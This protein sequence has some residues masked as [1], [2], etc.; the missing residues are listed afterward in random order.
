MNI[1]YAFDYLTT[2]LISFR[3]R[4]LGLSGFLWRVDVDEGIVFDVALLR[5]HL[6]QAEVGGEQTLLTRSNQM[7]VGFS[8]VTEEEGKM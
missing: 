3:S 1:V 8:A 4:I 5:V 6:E 2:S 7:R